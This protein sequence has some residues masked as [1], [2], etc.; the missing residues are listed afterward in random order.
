[1]IQCME[2]SGVYGPINDAVFAYIIH[3]NEQLHDDIKKKETAAKKKLHGSVPVI[4]RE[5][6]DACV[7]RILSL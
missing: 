3:L 2:Y 6:R 1:M 4:N 7:S 5:K